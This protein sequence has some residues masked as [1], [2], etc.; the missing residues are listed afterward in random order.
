MYLLARWVPAGARSLHHPAV[1]V[2]VAMGRNSLPVFA[3]G[4][5][6]AIAFHL[7]ALRWELSMVPILL[8]TLSG[9]LF[10]AG[11]ALRMTYGRPMPAP[12][13]TPVGER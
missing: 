9:V 11:F 2:L 5:L 10:Q 3:G 7:L 12:P 13:L 8:L 1:S 6:L 4:T